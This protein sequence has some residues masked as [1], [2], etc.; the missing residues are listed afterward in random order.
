MEFLEDRAKKRGGGER[1]FEVDVVFAF[2]E[3]EEEGVEGGRDTFWMF[4]GW[5]GRGGRGN[6]NGCGLVR[7][8]RREGRRGG[9]VYR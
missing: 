8:G 5:G 2:G 4:G 6:G 3:G 7:G 9:G 1:A